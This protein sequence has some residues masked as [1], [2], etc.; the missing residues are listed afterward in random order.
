MPTVESDGATIYYE[1]H[2][3]GSGFPLLLL[4]PGG[5]NSVIPI[6]HS[7]PLDAIAA[8]SNEFRVIA[9][10]QRN[11]GQSRGPLATSDAWGMYAADQLAVL[12]ALGIERALMLG[13]CIGCTFILKL[14]EIAPERVVAGVL[15][16]P[17]G[18][19]PEQPDVFG[20][21]RWRPWGQSLIDEGAD[22]TMETVDAFGHSLF[23]S[24]FVFAVSRDF[25][26]TIRTPMLL[27]DGNDAAHPKETS[28]EVAALLPNVE[29]VERWKTAEAVG[30]AT[31]KVRAFLRAH[32]PSGVR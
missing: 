2:G 23:D 13:S 10:D 6:W 29:R 32:T 15:L 21:D 30:P 17:I 27:L 25:V 5:L 9:M 1:E 22:F 11:A 18:L 3:N 31:E 14:A 16:Q 4:S 28:E 8:F 19:N 20:P 24:D 7:Q 26:K 12:D